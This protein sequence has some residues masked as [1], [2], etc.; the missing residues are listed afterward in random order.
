ML[1]NEKAKV[2]GG[3]NPVKGERNKKIHERNKTTHK[4]KFKLK[5]RAI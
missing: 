3:V 4:E 5:K 2:A 1:S